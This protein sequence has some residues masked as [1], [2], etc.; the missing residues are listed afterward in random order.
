MSFGIF[1]LS[2]YHSLSRE[3][4]YWS[5]DEDL[6]VSCV[7]TCMSRNKFQEIKNYIHF[8]E[9]YSVDQNVRA[10]QKRTEKKA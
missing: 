9:N 4:L 8:A 10:S 3:K 7:S 5:L 2:G 6:S 1:F